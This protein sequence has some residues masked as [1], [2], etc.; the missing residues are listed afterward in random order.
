MIAD[1]AFNRGREQTNLAKNSL[2]NLKKELVHEV[3][4]RVRTSLLFKYIKISFFPVLL[5]TLIFFGVNLF[6]DG[7]LQ[8]GSKLIL[9]ALG[10]NVGCWLSLAVRTRG[11]EF[12]QILPILGDQKGVHTRIIFVMAF[13]VVMAI[14]MKSGLLSI[15]LGEFS[16]LSIET[17]NYS[18]LSAGFIMGFAE[19]LFVD[20]FQSKVNSVNI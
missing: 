4:P 20:K 15:Q 3:G 9:V 8:Y 14:L 12:S 17:K 10:A 5:L 2:D 1:L 6:E 11:M 18:A 16:S 7:S 19:K 13:S